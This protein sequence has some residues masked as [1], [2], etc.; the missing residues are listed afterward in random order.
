[1]RFSTVLWRWR[2][3]RYSLRRPPDDLIYRVAGT[4]DVEWFQKSGQLSV[5][6]FETALGGCGR[7][8]A[9]F[10]HILDFGCG[11]GRI[12]S[13]MR[14]VVAEERLCGVDIDSQAINW[15]RPY[16]PGMELHVTAPLPPLPFPGGRFDLVYCHSVLTHLD[17]DYQNAWLSE[18]QRV[19]T[20]GAMLL[21]SFHGEHAFQVLEESWRRVQADP[22]P[23][24]DS[25]QR[26]GTLFIR[27]DE[28]KN[29]PFPDFYHT[30]FHAPDYVRSHWGS[31]FEVVDLLPRGSLGYQDLAVLKR[32]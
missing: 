29:G 16:L 30:M 10:H 1:M 13:W 11:C 20:P 12:L 7:R 17:L 14:E 26:D 9:E 23:L 3:R 32:R 28:W 27:D 19:T 15:L 8:L 18:L 6:D 4:R 24:R 5:S 25:W 22:Q 2:K 21:L 31:Y